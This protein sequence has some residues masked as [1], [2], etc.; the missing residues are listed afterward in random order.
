[1]ESTSWK[2]E[3]DSLLPLVAT[4]SGAFMYWPNFCLKANWLLPPTVLLK[5]SSETHLN[6]GLNTQFYPKTIQF[7]G[8]TQGHPVYAQR[9][10]DY[11]CIAA[12]SRASHIPLIFLHT[13]GWWGVEKLS[14]S[15]LDLLHSHFVI[16][17]HGQPE[18]YSTPEKIS[19]VF[20]FCSIHISMCLL[21]IIICTSVFHTC[22][23]LVAHTY[24]W[25]RWYRSFIYNPWWQRVTEICIH[26]LRT[27][28]KHLHSFQRP[29]CHSGGQFH[30]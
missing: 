28:V 4:S 18:W 10:L 7:P 25:S 11:S 1:M 30:H 22:I 16:F 12:F 19:S 29:L 15:S 24:L 27:S 5:G 21:E 17:E 14:I 20:F 6:V 8:S 23:A 13:V 9:P 26:M 3:R 2:K